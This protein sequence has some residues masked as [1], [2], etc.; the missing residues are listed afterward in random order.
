MPINPVDPTGFFKPFHNSLWITVIIEMLIVAASCYYM[1]APAC[2]PPVNDPDDLAIV[3]G[4]AFGW[5]DSVYWSMTL[6]VQTPDKAPCTWGG[7]IV[8][9]AHGWFMLI[10]LASYTANLANFLTT[11]NM[12]P[13]LSSWSEV[14]DSFG[15]YTI[16]LQRGSAHENYIN[17]QRNLYGHEYNITWTQTWEDA[18]ALVEDGVVDATFHDEPIAQQYLKSVN[19]KECKLAETGKMFSSFGYG[20]AFPFDNPDFIA[21]SQAIVYLKENGQLRK[22]MRKYAVG[23]AGSAPGYEALDCTL[24]QGGSDDE[25]FHLNDMGGLLIMTAIVI[26][27]G[28]II[29]TWE[30][31]SHDKAALPCLQPCQD[32]WCPKP[33]DIADDD[34]QGYGGGRR[35]RRDS[36]S[37]DDEMAVT[38]FTLALSEG[39]KKGIL[40]AVEKI[41][42]QAPPPFTAG[43][44]GIEM[45]ENAGFVDSPRGVLGDVGA[46]AES[47]PG[48]GMLLGG[49][50]QVGSM[51]GVP[52]INR[53]S[54]DALSP[55]RPYSSIPKKQ[56]SGAVSVDTSDAGSRMGAFMPTHEPKTPKAPRGLDMMGVDE[57]EEEGATDETAVAGDGHRYNI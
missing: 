26:A 56:V 17:V 15:Q 42:K 51:V 52:A 44:N 20:F 5:W 9:M 14:Q 27:L 45:M 23:S 21:F 24:D 41:G 13:T 32:C 37:E 38:P 11:E 34:S 22:I 1:E 54:G 39:V 33:I 57:E 29:N 16:A 3:P 35:W 40:E 6:L 46:A 28:F 4:K 48:V 2:D 10:V 43:M 19:M 25:S 8:L 36:E 30:R 7:K 50:S 47:L 12:A 18:L 31:H 53:D 49:L 55:R